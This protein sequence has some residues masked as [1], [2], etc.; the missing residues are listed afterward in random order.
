MTLWPFQLGLSQIT[1]PISKLIVHLCIATILSQGGSTTFGTTYPDETHASNNADFAAS[2]LWA[3]MQLGVQYDFYA[4]ASA[5]MNV[6]AFIVPQPLSLPM[7]STARWLTDVIGLRPT[8]TWASTNITQPV[9]VPNNTDHLTAEVAG[10][11]L[12][13]MD[14]DVSVSAMDICMSRVVFCVKIAHN[15]AVASESLAAI[16]VRSPTFNMFNHTTLHPPTDGSTVFIAGQCVSGCTVDPTY[17]TVWLNF[18]EIPTF[19]IQL[20]PAITFMRYQSWHLAFLVC[21]PNA[22]I[23]T[24]E[25]RA[26]GSARLVVQPLSEGKQLTSQGNLFPQDTTTMLSFALSSMTNIGPSNSSDMSG[27]GSRLQRKFLFGSQQVDSWPGA[28]AGS[29]T[30]ILN[31]SFLPVANLSEGFAQML[32]SASK[33]TFLPFCACCR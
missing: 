32:Q 11:Y 16:A 30:Q 18:T 20:P 7:T 23:E 28:Y 13:D 31:V 27:L 6:S 8:C 24:R 10:V 12:E 21:K 22:V 14:L 2:I 3:E 1:A 5:E 9:I 25:V 4:A 26:E 15:A 33:G 19:T 29:G 17:N